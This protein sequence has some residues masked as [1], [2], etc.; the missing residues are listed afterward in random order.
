VQLFSDS[1]ILTKETDIT[2]LNEAHSFL[3]PGRSF[4]DEFSSSAAA[5]IILDSYID[6]RYYP[7]QK[8]VLALWTPCLC[9]PDNSY[10]YVF[11]I[12]PDFVH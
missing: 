2:M 6:V 9:F 7:G 8:G 12:L 3:D 1:W 4:A 11:A 10:P 5:T